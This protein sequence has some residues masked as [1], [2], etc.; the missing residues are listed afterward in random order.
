MEHLELLE[1]YVLQY[2]NQGKV[3]ISGDF[4]CR[5][6]SGSNGILNFD[7]YLDEDSDRFIDLPFTNSKD[8]VTDMRWRNL[9]SFVKS[10]I[11]G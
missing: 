6:D 1:N 8:S 5:C 10:Y 2:Q 11:C 9:Q 7:K 3:S 4:N